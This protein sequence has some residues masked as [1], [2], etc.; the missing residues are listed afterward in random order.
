MLSLPNNMPITG[1]IRKNKRQIPP[2]FRLANKD[3][4]ATQFCF[5][6]KLTLLFHT[7][8]KNKIVLV[9]LCIWI[10]LTSLKANQI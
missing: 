4:S 3:P 5:H 1:T 10:Q 2:Q 9:P 8:K 7:P 6:K